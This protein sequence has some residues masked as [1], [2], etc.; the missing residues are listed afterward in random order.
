MIRIYILFLIFLSVGCKK[1][2]SL[3]IE[4]NR[5]AN[6]Y[7]VSTIKVRNYVNKLFIDLLGRTPTDEEKERETSLLQDASLSMDARRKL[8]HKLQSDTTFIEGDSSYKIAYY[9]RIYNLCKARLLEGADD[10]EFS[11]RIGNLNFAVTIARLEGDSVRVFRSLYE[12]EKN[13]AVLDSR[14]ALRNGDISINQMYA[15][16]L[17]NSI[18]DVINMNSFNF[19][20]A[21]FDDLFDRFPTQEEFNSAYPIIENNEGNIFW[22]VYIDNKFDYCKTLTSGTAFNEG[23][24]QWTY[25]NLLGR[26]C[27][28]LELFNRLQEF[29]SHQNYQLIQEKILQSN[30]YAQF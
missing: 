26:A 7:T 13:K 17:N 10:S 9:N 8:I 14:I 20:N 30:E 3:L 11:Q 6:P 25:L 15:R 12:I 5:I 29:N 4:D 28:S 19:I 24:I 16:M 2:T 18:Y 1:E 21:S 23:L 22:G 27:S